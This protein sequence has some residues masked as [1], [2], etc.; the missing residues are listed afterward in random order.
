MELTNRV[1]QR[2]D[3]LAE[4]Y[5]DILEEV[6]SIESPTSDKA[7]VDEAGS[8][9]ASLAAGLGWEVE[10]FPQA[11][12]GDPVC[13]TANAAAESAPISLS[14]HI[15]TVHPKGRFGDPVVRRD[16]ERMYG[17]GVLDCKGGVVASFLAVEALLAEGYAARPLRILLQT[18]E[19]VGSS[20]SDHA[21]INWICGKAKDSVAFLNMEG[22]KAGQAILVRKGIL[23]L[24]FTVRGRACHSS[25]CFEGANAIAEAANKLLRLEALKEPEGL[26]CNCGVIRGGT[27]ANSVAE[28]CEFIADIRFASPEEEAKALSTV[29][30]PN[31][32]DCPIGKPVPEKLECE[33][34]LKVGDNIT[35]DHIMPAGAK[36]LPYRSNIPYLS[37][38]CFAVCDE[39]F[40]ERAKAKGQGI[41]IGGSN[42]GQGSSREHAA[43]VPLYLGIRAVIAKSFARIHADNLVN[44]GILPL[45]FADPDDYDR[46]SEGDL[47]SI[48]GIS[49]GL[50]NGELTL[51]VGE[52]AVKL[53]VN[54]SERQKEM[55]KAG[56]LL[57]AT[58]G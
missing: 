36:I 21:T 2:I 16:G 22:Y 53:A 51:K 48:D 54:L 23:R 50:K 26:T 41:I 6:C 14:G 49:D 40:P 34:V 52:K 30:G 38:F 24:A 7:K 29:K 45:T 58:K 42:Y 1:L 28:E 25:L 5:L 47:L 27:V 33:C 43:L 10:R 18:D 31:I 46:I 32:K 9:L 39:S 55:I 3:A 44:A 19:E 37:K 15:D 11:V 8:Y 56:G 17:P 35:T 12:A 13:I 4:R 57:A 20:I